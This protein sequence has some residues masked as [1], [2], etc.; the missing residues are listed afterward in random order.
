MGWQQTGEGAVLRI[1]LPFSGFDTYTSWPGG[2]IK[3]GMGDNSTS[4]WKL[5]GG[6]ER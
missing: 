6:K 1:F 3:V 4:L 5:S 2:K